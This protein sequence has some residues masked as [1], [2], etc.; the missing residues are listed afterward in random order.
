MLLVGLTNSHKSGMKIVQGIIIEST[1]VI[2]ERLD[3]P[4]PTLLIWSLLTF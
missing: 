3:S 2:E 1:C 4:V